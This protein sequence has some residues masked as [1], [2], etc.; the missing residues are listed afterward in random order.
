MRFPLSLEE[1]LPSGDVQALHNRQYRAVWDGA[2]DKKA[3]SGFLQRP[4]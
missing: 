3:S 2:G 1:L 4:A